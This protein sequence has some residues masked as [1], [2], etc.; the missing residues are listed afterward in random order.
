[1]KLLQSLTVLA[2]E[3]NEIHTDSFFVPVVSAMLKLRTLHLQDNLIAIPVPEATLSN[4]LKHIKAVTLHGNPYHDAGV[5]AN[6]T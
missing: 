1:M 5:G 2:L 4:D 6:S 3:S